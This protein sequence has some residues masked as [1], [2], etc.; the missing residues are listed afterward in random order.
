MTAALANGFRCAPEPTL[1]VLDGVH[2]L[3]HRV[4][5][6]VVASLVE[7]VPPGSQ[8]LLTTRTVARPSVRAPARRAA[9]GRA[10]NGRSPP[11]RRGGRG[12]PA[13]SGSIAE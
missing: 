3:R 10:G 6:A 9:A 2:L 1:L 12:G 8:V 4:C 5:R 11:E 13:R 7:N